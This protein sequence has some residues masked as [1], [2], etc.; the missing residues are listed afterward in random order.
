M[1]IAYRVK[2][3]GIDPLL[4]KLQHEPMLSKPLRRLMSRVGILG[5][6]SAKA[7]APRGRTGQLSSKIT[8]R[9]ST[10]AIPTFVAI[11]ASAMSKQGYPYPRLLEFS[12]KHGRREW[13]LR[14]IQGVM[15]Q[16]VGYV[17]DTAREIEQEWKR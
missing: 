9:M 16:I 2:L 3:E 13:L 8:T 4:K 1:P 5:K 11:R 10:K 17:N 7:G 12:G 14:S 15:G 6:G